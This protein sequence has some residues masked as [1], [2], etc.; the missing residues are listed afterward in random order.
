M[1]KPAIYWRVSTDDQETSPANQIEIC[2]QYIQAMEW[3]EALVF[4]DEAVSGRTMIRPGWDQLIAEVQAGH[5][6]MIVAKTLSRLARTEKFL[7]VYDEILQPAGCEFATVHERFDTSSAM[8]RFAMG[9]MLLANKLFA[10]QT[11]EAIAA[12]QKVRAHQGYWM[13]G[14]MPFGMRKAESGI[15]EADPERWPILVKLFELKAGGKSR[16]EILEYLQENEIRTVKGNEF[17]HQTLG[18]I[19]ANPCYKGTVI[20][21][22][23]PL[24]V[25]GRWKCQIDE[26]LWEQAQDIVRRYG[27]KPTSA[28]YLL[29]GKVWTSQFVIS[30]PEGRAGEPLKLI[31]YHCQGRPEADGTPRYYH[32]YMLETHRRKRGGVKAVA[33]DDTAQHWTDTRLRAN[34]LDS[35]ILDYLVTLADADNSGQLRAQIDEV[36]EGNLAELRGQLLRMKRQKKEAARTEAVATR[37]ITYCSEEHFHANAAALNQALIDATRA[38]EGLTAR[39]EGLEAA[40]DRL[41]AASTETHEVL[42]MVNVVSALRDQQDTAGLREI[43][44]LLVHSVEITA[45]EAEYIIKP[46]LYALP[47]VQQAI[48]R[49]IPSASKLGDLV[50]MELPI[51]KAVLCR[52]RQG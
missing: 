43:I 15:P 49:V 7:T 14:A 40:V 13:R 32:Y 44:N 19:L 22:G 8:G 28:P 20:Y 51:A 3:P 52:G 41:E 42:Q 45:A 21:K 35:V 36:T 37:K 30:S 6:N 10:E 2:R 25:R 18:W 5:V 12:T 47:A 1:I 27:R 17:T 4:G 33:L 38:R 29:E 31:C 16:A 34:E 11:G 39:I 46:H 26:S 24:P 48:E 9:M 50:V 23:Q